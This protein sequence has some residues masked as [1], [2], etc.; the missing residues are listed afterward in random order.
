M[1]RAVDWPWSAGTAA[2][3]RLQSS[4]SLGAGGH[5]IHVRH[6]EAANQQDEGSGSRTTGLAMAFM[7]LEAA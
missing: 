4:V 7:L 6:G 1:P 2:K 3:L 5:R